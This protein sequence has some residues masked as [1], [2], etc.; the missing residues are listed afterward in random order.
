M[1]FSNAPSIAQFLL[2]M[3]KVE[4]T[5]VYEARIPQNVPVIVISNHRSFLDALILIHALPQPISIACHHFMGK[6]PGISTIIKLLN[7]FPLAQPQYR[8]QQFFELANQLLIHQK[9][10]GLFPEGAEPMVNI[11]QPQEVKPFSR[12]F[13][14]LALQ[15]PTASVIILPVAIASLEETVYQTFPIRWL[16]L[17]DASEPCFQR[18]GL[19]PVVIYRRTRLLFGRP[20]EITTEQKQQYQGKKAKYLAT[21]IT[22]HCREQIIELLTR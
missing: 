8:R 11:T 6:A 9:W 10:V 4:V 3:M 19:H 16:S 2:S 5:K 18:S 17:F 21:Q 20:Y 14:H 12:G 7:C 1:N 22:H 15:A 13:A